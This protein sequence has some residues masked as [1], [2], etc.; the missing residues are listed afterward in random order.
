M[1]LLSSLTCHVITSNSNMSSLLYVRN[2]AW[3]DD[4]AFLLDDIR[5]IAFLLDDIRNI[6]FLLDG[7]KPCNA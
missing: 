5:M 6:A 7:A 2:N 1:S 3:L 4:I